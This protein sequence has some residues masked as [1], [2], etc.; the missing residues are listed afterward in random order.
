MMPDAIEPATTLPEPLFRL[1]ADLARRDDVCSVSCPFDD[2]ALWR[3]LVTE[4]LRRA[5]D[6]GL[7]LQ[8]AFALCG[9]DSGLDGVPFEEWG[10]EVH[11]PYEGACGADLFILP[12]WHRFFA[13]KLR[14]GGKLRWAV[15]K[16]CNRVI[17]RGEYGEIA[18]ATRAEICD[19]WWLYTATTPHENCN[20]IHDPVFERIVR[21]YHLKQGQ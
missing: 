21:E 14:E 15:H 4:Q 7:E 18:C 3:L 16:P 8:R 20:P 9:P 12:S 11:I 17:V 13:D 10:G 5:E 19:G 1:I 6:S 2:V